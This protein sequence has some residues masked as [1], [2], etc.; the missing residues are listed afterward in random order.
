MAKNSSGYAEQ[1]SPQIGAIIEKG[2]MDWQIL[3]QKS[4]KAD[5]ELSGRWAAEEP[6]SD[7]GVYVRA[8]REDTGEVV[9]PWQRAGDLE[10]RKWSATIRDI[11]AGGLYR[12]ET[13]LNLHNDPIEGS[14]RGDMV[15]HVGVGDLYVITGQS[16]S[17]GV[18]RD[19]VYDPPEIGVH[20]LRNNGKWDLASHPMNESTDTAH[21]VN[22]EYFNPGHSPYLSF[23]KYLKRNIGCPVGLI[24]ASLGGS[25]L[26]VWNA[27]EDGALYRNMLEII[28]SQESGVKGILW[29]QGCADTNE[30]ESQTYLD[31][32][33]SMV[34]HLREDLNDPNLPVLTVQL[35]RLVC[36]PDGPTDR[37]WGKV[38]EAQRQAAMQIP[39]VFVVS[40]I[41]SGLSDGIH[42]SAAANMILGERLA[43]LAL[44]DIYGSALRF[45]FPNI[46]S[47]EKIGSDQ[48]R[49]TFANVYDR[50]FCFDVDWRELPFTVED[51][52]GFVP[53]K[54]CE[55]KKNTVIIGTDRKLVGK[56]RVHGA[57]EQNPKFLVPVDFETHLPMLSFYGV[58]VADGNC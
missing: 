2:P 36:P 19:F 14:V 17:A 11:P 51:E 21:E 7:P 15:H 8:V 37:W 1:I 23:A 4:G 46:L 6:V 20:L 56:C 12:I 31:R 28:H 29:Y 49:L 48:L 24:Q 50:L 41:D 16:N 32:F 10:E 43:K 34:A 3:Q 30:S 47:A 33:K 25:Q 35:N 55:M 9:A 58:D 52:E 45:G 38:R 26:R 22:R 5:L 57:W 42:N 39:N 53:L 13:C 18:G 40:S 27:E 44:K 54:H